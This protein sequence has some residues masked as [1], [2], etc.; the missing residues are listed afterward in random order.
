MIVVLVMLSL[1]LAVAQPNMTGLFRKGGFKAQAEQLVSTMQKAARTAAETGR[2]YE[3]II[4]LA[5]QGY[6]LR[7]IHGSV[8][9]RDMEGEIIEDSYFNRNCWISYVEFDDY[10]FVNDTRAWFWVG[11]AG[12]Q[13][14]GKI[15]FLDQGDQPWSIVVNRIN[16]NVRLVPGDMEL[17]RPKTEDEMSF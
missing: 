2:R 11:P 8:L 10:D 16:R 12:W 14:G 15:V 1:M 9:S 13:Y 5:D 17:L 4:D 6:M 3:V 7:E